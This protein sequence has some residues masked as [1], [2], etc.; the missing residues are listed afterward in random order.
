MVRA[1][2]AGRQG[3]SKHGGDWDG[4]GCD[5]LMVEG[6]GWSVEG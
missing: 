3:Q 1:S 6:G 4:E 2:K 5:G